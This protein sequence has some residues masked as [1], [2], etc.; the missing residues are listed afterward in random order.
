MF[1]SNTN[2]NGPTLIEVVDPTLSRDDGT[3]AWFLNYI[4]GR[5]VSP[6]IKRELLVRL[7]HDI[8]L[9]REAYRRNILTLAYS[10]ENPIRS[11]KV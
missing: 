10:R 5:K 11:T 4:M 7:E 2:K 9:K 1:I 8:K 3:V 6:A